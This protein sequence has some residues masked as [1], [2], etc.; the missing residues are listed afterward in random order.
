VP[1]TAGDDIKLTVAR[2][3]RKPKGSLH[4]L[5]RRMKQSE[6]HLKVRGGRRGDDDHLQVAPHALHLLQQ[7]QHCASIR[8]TLCKEGLT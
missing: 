2:T 6:T 8:R 1:Q 5:H 3:P 7:P 4:V